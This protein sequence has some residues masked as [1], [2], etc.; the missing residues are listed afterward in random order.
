MVR[1]Q[2]HFTAQIEFIPN[3]LLSWVFCKGTLK[4]NGVSFL[5]KLLD[6][7]Q[8]TSIKLK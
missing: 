1:F 8:S 6:R 7:V 2:G 4:T 3:K 5:C